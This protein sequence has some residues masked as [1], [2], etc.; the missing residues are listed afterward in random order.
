MSTQCQLK[1]VSADV[2]ILVA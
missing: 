1:S 2:S